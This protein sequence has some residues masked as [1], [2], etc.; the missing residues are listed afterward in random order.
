IE[1]TENI[2]LALAVCQH[3]GIETKDATENMAEVTPDPGALRSYSL[4]FDHKKFDLVYAMAANDPEST[5]MIWD[6]LEKEVYDNVYV[7]INCRH[8]RL[9]RSLQFTLMVR[10]VFKD[11]TG[12]ILTGQATNVLYSRIIR[13]VDAN[14]I[15]DI[16]D[17]T[18]VK[19]CRIISEHIPDKS[20][21]FATGNTV[22]YGMELINTMIN[23][24]HSSC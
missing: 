4:T 24:G 3:C 23:K 6:T 22:G 9:D 1:H 20:L 13:S 5:R 10:D 18:A 21:I 11:V 14:M 2:A 19:A 16:G 15:L 8:D 17:M 7:L 12:F